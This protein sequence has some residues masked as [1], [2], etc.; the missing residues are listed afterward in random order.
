MD[1]VIESVTNTENVDD[2][3]DTVYTENS[4]YCQQ[5]QK[6][7]KIYPCPRCFK[8][9]AQLP[10]AN[11]HCLAAKTA[12]KCVCPNCNKTMWKKNI[13]KH[14]Q[15]CDTNKIRPSKATIKCSLCE[16]AMSS[17]QRLSSHME[18]IH[19]VSTEDGRSGSVI[20][21]HKCDFSHVKLSVVKVHLSK[22][23]P[24]GVKLYCKECNHFCYSDSGLSK[25]I[26]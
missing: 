5:L 15:S 21:C 22:A 11:K 10:S 9:F 20:K 25:H 18:N 12:K 4:D 16:K 7:P 14:Q 2:S 3:S 8:L 17:R 24:S 19:G 23:H 26:F 1:Q 6:K 13:K